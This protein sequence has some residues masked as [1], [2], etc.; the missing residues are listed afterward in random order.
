M[1]NLCRFLVLAAFLGVLSLFSSK[2]ASAHVVI[3]NFET[4]ERVL[5]VSN[6]GA[7]ESEK[8]ATG[9]VDPSKDTTLVLDQ[10]FSYRKGPGGQGR[11]D[12]RQSR[13][14]EGMLSRYSSRRGSA[15]GGGGGG[16]S[17]GG[18]SRARRG[19]AGGTDLAQTLVDVGNPAGR[20]ST[21]PASQAPTS[22]GAN[23]TSLSSG[24]GGVGAASG[25][26]GSGRASDADQIAGS[27][28]SVPTANPGTG[29]AVSGT[30]EPAAL[31]VWAIMGCCG[32][33][34]FQVRRKWLS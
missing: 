6:A 27:G 33:G 24:S 5:V 10:R 7:A 28:G 19:S 12:S 31:A 18:R 14:A 4:G 1:T 16:G 17:R 15:G 20:S 2:S 32:Y 29:V 23:L 21:T 34:M 8:R 13:T 26:S 25:G 22:N 11:G 3:N 9:A 30:P